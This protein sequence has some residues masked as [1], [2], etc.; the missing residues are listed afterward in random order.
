MTL[1]ETTV[2][3]YNTQV[4]D[5]YYREKQAIEQQIEQG[6]SNVEYLQER[7]RQI[8][9]QIEQFLQRREEGNG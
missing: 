3:E 6:S 9:E 1:F 5:G 4:L 8:N 2:L 7:L